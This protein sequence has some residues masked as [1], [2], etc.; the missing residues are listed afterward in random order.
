MQSFYWLM[1]DSYKETFGDGAIFAVTVIS[2]I[3]VI[4]GQNKPFHLTGPWELRMKG[5]AR[6]MANQRPFS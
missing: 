6:L 1:F 3:G 2:A 5:P 4:L